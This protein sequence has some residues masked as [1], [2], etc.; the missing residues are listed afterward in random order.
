MYNNVY[1]S[2]FRKGF[3]LVE[4]VVVVLIIGIL[5]A[6]AAPKLFNTSQTARESGTRQ[7]LAVLRS[8]IELYKAQNDT[9]PTAANLQTALAGFLK[10]PFPATQIGNKSSTV[11]AGS[12]S[13]LTVVAGGAGWVYNESNGD[14]AVNDAAGIAW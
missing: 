2:K 9:Y 8:S 5:S 6:V 12:S 10:G 14:I 11:V 3:T 4:L 7:S 1:A 13:P